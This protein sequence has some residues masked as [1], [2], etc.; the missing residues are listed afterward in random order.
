MRREPLGLWA[1]GQQ[2][3]QLCMLGSST[4]TPPGC[5]EP[6]LKAR[7]PHFQDHSPQCAGDRVP[8]APEVTIPRLT[9]QVDVWTLANAGFG[10]AR[11]T[12]QAGFPRVT[13]LGGGVHQHQLPASL[14]FLELGYGC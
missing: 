13:R 1:T 7:E 3:H 12:A 2:E 11:A 8:S 10:V 5:P 6:G 14:I 9:M 4:P